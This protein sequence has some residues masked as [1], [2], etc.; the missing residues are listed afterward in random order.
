MTTKAE[1]DKLRSHIE[2]GRALS[3]WRADGRW[4]DEHQHQWFVSLLDQA[5]ELEKLK[6]D[7]PVRPSA[8]AIPEATN[9]VALTAITR[10]IEFPTK[11]GWYWFQRT[12]PVNQDEP[13]TPT[14]QRIEVIALPDGTLS[15]ELGEVHDVARWGRWFGP[16][17]APPADK[18]TPAK[19]PPAQHEGVSHPKALHHEPKAKD[20]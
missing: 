16:E 14:L 1:R 8:S 11:A 12:R 7:K 13:L 15:C 18:V 5:D 10:A 2:D 3:T 4:T 6:A 19:A 17:V 20:H 9:M